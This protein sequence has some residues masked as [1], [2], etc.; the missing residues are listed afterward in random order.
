MRLE[1][2][3][4][5]LDMNEFRYLIHTE[6]WHEKDVWQCVA[7]FNSVTAANIALNALNKEDKLNKYY[8]IFFNSHHF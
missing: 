1:G 4:S 7:I 8:I 6:M 2:W 5:K 3:K